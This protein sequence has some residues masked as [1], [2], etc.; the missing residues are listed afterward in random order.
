M[1]GTRRIHSPHTRGSALSPSEPS[2][3]QLRSLLQHEIV[4][5]LRSMGPMSLEE[6]ARRCRRQRTSIRSEV[7]RLKTAGWP[8]ET[9]AG[10]LTLTGPQ[11]KPICG[12]C[13]AVLRRGNAD[14][15]CEP[16]RRSG[17]A[18]QA[19]RVGL[20]DKHDAEARRAFRAK[21]LA[22]LMER[23]GER[24][25]PYPA[26]GLDIAV[27]EHRDVVANHIKALRREHDI[28]GHSSTG[29]GGNAGWSWHGPRKEE[30]DV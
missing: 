28:R 17:R 2:A 20:Y 24:V 10:R 13:G 3:P 11:K 9:I 8:I 12:A 16:C 1:I 14:R 18:K 25:S 29:Q 26:L 23:P 19:A 21:L 5:T 7:A 27:R 22:L 4:D 15:Y 6:L 30:A